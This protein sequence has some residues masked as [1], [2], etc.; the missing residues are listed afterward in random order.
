M[1]VS[2]F[3]EFYTHIECLH[4]SNEEIFAECIVDEIKP[5]VDSESDNWEFPPEEESF[6]KSFDEKPKN[7]LS[8][9]KT[10]SEYSSSDDN[11]HSNRKYELGSEKVRTRQSVLRTEN[12][13]TSS[14]DVEYRPKKK[15]GRPRN[16]EQKKIEEAIRVESGAETPQELNINNEPVRKRGRP[17]KN[18][19][20]KPRSNK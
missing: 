15:R 2:V 14:I 8:R 10:E 19:P 20:V 7:A 17:R 13:Q 12:Q 6:N 4:R 3:H 18:D 11:R 9:K 5:S 16:G 1:K